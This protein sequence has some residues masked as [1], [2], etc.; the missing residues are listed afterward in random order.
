[1]VRP[2][3][4]T[5]LEGISCRAEEKRSRQ[6]KARTGGDSRKKEREEKEM[7]EEKKA[8][9]VEVSCK[10]ARDER[11]GWNRPSNRPTCTHEGMGCGI[12]LPD[13]Q[14]F[15]ILTII[16]NYNLRIKFQPIRRR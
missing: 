8:V 6:R 3:P 14:A 7:R 4:T 10:R 2:S 11:R 1:M 9:R 15:K 16:C 13:S 5:V 12:Q